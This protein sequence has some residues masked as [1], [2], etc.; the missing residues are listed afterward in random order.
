[1]DKVW[2]K[3]EA[4]RIFGI[5][6]NCSHPHCLDCL[7]TWRKSR[8]DF[9]LGVIKSVSWRG[10]QGGRERSHRGVGSETGR[11]TCDYSSPTS[12][13]IPPRRACPQC[14]VPS[15]YIIPCK[16][17]VSKGPKKEQLIRNF[18]ARTSQIRCRFFMRGNGRCPFKSD[19]IYLHQLPDKA[20]TSDPPWPGSM[21]LASVVGKTAFLGGTE[22]EE[23][24]FFMDCALT[25]AFWGSELLLDPNSSY[26][27][28]L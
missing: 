10:Q 15:S 13:P 20:P 21:Q 28:L 1:M 3:P 7:R 4:K 2:D 22:P 9:P 27:C 8:G 16:F 6:P 26:H 24:V 14:R 18:K 12:H 19:C 17:W 23:E 25:M 5:L 11:W